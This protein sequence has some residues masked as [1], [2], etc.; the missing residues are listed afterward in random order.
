MER[1]KKM[2]NNKNNEPTYKATLILS[3]VEDNPHGADIQL[4]YDPELP[5]N[6]PDEEVPPCYKMMGHIFHR[7]VRPQLDSEITDDGEVRPIPKT[8]N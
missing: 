8:L 2:T 5:A 7:Y 1:Q 3:S 4:I 6:T